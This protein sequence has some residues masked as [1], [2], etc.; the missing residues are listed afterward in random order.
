[1]AE[2]ETMNG[3]GNA[4]ANVA[5]ATTPA[6][7]P[8]PADYAKLGAK[9][10]YDPKPPEAIRLYVTGLAG[11]GKTTFVS[12]IPDSLILDYEKGA[13][14][15]P[16]GKA[17]R[18]AIRNYAHHHSIITQ[19][20]EDAKNNKRRFKRVIFDTHDGWV[21]L[22]KRNLAKD[23]STATRIIEDIGEY[24]QKGHGYA[25]LHGRCRRVLG[26]IEDAGYAWAVV[27]HLT[28]ITET[29]PITYKDVTR[30]RPILSKGSVGPVV[31]NAELH[32]TVYASTKKETIE[33]KQQIGSKVIKTKTEK[34]VTRYHIYTRPTEAKTMEGKRRG[35][36][37]LPGR[38]EI[39]MVGGWDVLRTAYIKAVEESKKTNGT[40]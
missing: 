2:N 34:E 26:D 33:G 30:I 16:S 9:V 7:I 19:L 11:E 6:E 12:S 14:G 1:M 25:L 18:I 31:R 38:I 36:P 22:E 13:D 15:V 39:P 24:G 3:N 29:D 20:L 35:V 21:E 37:K 27:G 4:K 32:I 17:V 5:V 28:Y 23:K 40:K 10:G 8:I